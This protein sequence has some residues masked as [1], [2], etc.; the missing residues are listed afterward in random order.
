[1]VVYAYYNDSYVGSVISSLTCCDT[2]RETL[3][4]LM[5]RSNMKRVILLG[6]YRPPSGSAINAITKLNLWCEELVGL[7][8][9]ADIYIIGNFNVNLL[10]QTFYTTLI[11]EMCPT[12]ACIAWFIVQIGNHV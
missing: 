8:S 6:F 12:S 1:M 11:K 3:G 10:E 5:K 7:H 2:D 9:N 4:I